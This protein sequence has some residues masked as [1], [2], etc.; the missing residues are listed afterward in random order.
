MRKPIASPIPEAANLLLGL[1]LPDQL[2]CH[3]ETPRALGWCLSGTDKV[4]RAGA[5]PKMRA[6]EAPWLA[7]AAK[8]SERWGDRAPNESKALD[9]DADNHY[10][11]VTGAVAKTSRWQ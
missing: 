6:I 8:Q 11:T 3:R 10:S 9:D 1:P 5:V 4:T 7:R 2:R